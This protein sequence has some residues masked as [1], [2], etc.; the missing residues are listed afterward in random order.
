MSY[1]NDFNQYKALPISLIKFHD[2]LSYFCSNVTKVSDNSVKGCS[3]LSF[4]DE[5]VCQGLILQISIMLFLKNTHIKEDWYRSNKILLLFPCV[6]LEIKFWLKILHKV[7]VTWLKTLRTKKSSYEA[8][9]SNKTKTVIFQFLQCH[10]GLLFLNIFS[11]L[12]SHQLLHQQ[13][14]FSQTFR[15]S[16]KLTLSEKYFSQI[17]LQQVNPNPKPLNNQYL[18]SVT[19]VF[20]WCSLTF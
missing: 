20:Y 19:K 6:S 8:S 15:T 14:Y 5:F 17:F 13:V 12:V 16:F 9:L 18:L 4:I 7:S 1:R 10:G 2:T 11:F 3:L